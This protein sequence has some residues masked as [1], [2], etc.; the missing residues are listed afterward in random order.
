[1]LCYLYSSSSNLVKAELKLL[2][3]PTIFI[4]HHW[5]DAAEMGNVRMLLCWKGTSTFCDAGAHVVYCMCL[6]WVVWCQ[7]GIKDDEYIRKFAV[8]YTNTYKHTQQLNFIPVLSPTKGACQKVGAQ[9]QEIWHSGMLFALGS[10]RGF[11]LSG[12]FSLLICVC[13]CVSRGQTCGLVTFTV[14]SMCRKPADLPDICYPGV[15][16]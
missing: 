13:A 16:Q 12:L 11:L 14:N 9:I 8:T 1:M 10:N 15:L 4:H 2:P 6:L 7:E 3:I 5:P